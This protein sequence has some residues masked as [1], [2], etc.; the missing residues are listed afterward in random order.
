[1]ALN[2]KSTKNGSGSKIEYTQSEKNL[3]AQVIS[4]CLTLANE[5][6]VKPIEIEPKVQRI[7]SELNDSNDH[8]GIDT[9]ARAA[10]RSYIKDTCGH[11]E[12]FCSTDR[13]PKERDPTSMQLIMRN[14][15]E[16]LGRSDLKDAIFA[17]Y[18]AKKKEA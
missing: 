10:Y 14:G 5:P 4:C 15:L 7:V 8:D 9:L 12:T 6:I 2:L 13:F 18:G 11:K 17:T 1:M 3:A 16:I